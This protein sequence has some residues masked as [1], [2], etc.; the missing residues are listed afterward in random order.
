MTTK[1]ESWMRAVRACLL[2]PLE[3]QTFS[4]RLLVVL[5]CSCCIIAGALEP[6]PSLPLRTHPLVRSHAL[7]CTRNI[8][9]AGDDVDELAHA[10]KLEL[11][12]D[13]LT[14]ELASRQ[15]A[16]LAFITTAAKLIA[17]VI[18]HSLPLAGT[19]G[20]LGGAGSALSAALSVGSGFGGTGGSRFGGSGPLGASDARGGAGGAGSGSGAN[21]VAGY[22]WV[23]EQLRRDCPSV[24]SELQICK[25]LEYMSRR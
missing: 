6:S 13:P 3:T 21:W 7:S 16:A 19:G 14:E 15:R 1:P 17:P 2:T 20:P 24:A 23:I 8:C 4:S 10:A 11:V 25:A 22:D 18:G 5:L 12:R 9:N